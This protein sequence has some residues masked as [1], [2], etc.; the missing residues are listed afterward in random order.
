[1]RARHHFSKLTLALHTAFLTLSNNTAPS[2]NAAVSSAALAALLGSLATA[3][4]AA[5]AEGALQHSTA[6]AASTAAAT[7]AA[8]A[9]AKEEAA[10]SAVPMELKRR[11][12]AGVLHATAGHA[13]D[14]PYC[15][16]QDRVIAH[17]MRLYCA[18]PLE[19]ELVLSDSNSVSSSTSSLTV[20]S[21]I[22]SIAVESGPV[23]GRR[24]FELYAALFEG[25]RLRSLYDYST[26]GIAV[27]VEVL[28]RLVSSRLPALAAHL[29]TLDFHLD[30]VVFGWFQTLLLEAPLPHA[31]IG[32]VYD[33]WLTS[34]EFE[35]FFRVVLALL[36]L[37]QSTLL[38]L[39]FEGLQQ[40]FKVLPE[41]LQWGENSSGSSS[42]SASSVD[43]AAA[44]VMAAAAAVQ[45]EN[46]ELLFTEVE[47]RG[48]LTYVVHTNFTSTM[49]A[50]I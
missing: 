12:L 21:S 18:E 19:E 1:V 49:L 34:G 16:G 17:F 26:G 2:K 38:T 14:V 7:A 15:Q 9:V 22:T 23:A 36:T 43:S 6:T 10:W 5:S 28:L 44:A 11:C 20:D 8:A 4:A 25:Y 35:V 32:R 37:A 40:Y 39:D 31:V 45:L 33:W 47:A 27:C 30:L 50:L 13:S 48:H 29:R 3:A 41:L 46:G 42:S 24:L